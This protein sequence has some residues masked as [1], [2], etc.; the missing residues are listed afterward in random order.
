VGNK[1]RKNCRE[2]RRI[3]RGV[4]HESNMGEGRERQRECFDIVWRIEGGVISGASP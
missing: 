4:I 2:E 3:E 1:R